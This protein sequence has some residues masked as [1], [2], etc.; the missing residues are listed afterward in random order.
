[1]KVLVACEESQ[2]VCIA[3]REK[4]HEAYSCDILMPSGGHPE[5][6]ILGDA[7]DAIRGGIIKT[8]DGMTHDVGRFEFIIGF[9]P[10]TYMSAAG[11]CRMYPKKG[12]I[13]PARYE[14]AMKAKE[15]FLTILNTECEKVVVENP[16]PLKIIGL[17][18]PTQEVQPW[19]FGEPWSKRTLLWER[20][21]PPLKPT[22]IITD[23]KP[24]V[25]AGTSRKKGGDSYGARIPH[26]GF[27]RSKTFWGLA[28]AM[29][30]Q[31]G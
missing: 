3:F 16:L 22:N 31:W 15:F 25:P 23:Y 10:C 4:G 30:E 18:P 28:R 8:L 1:M 9:P 17:P 14:K 11:A 2:R 27:A 24:F 21:V 13:D 7:L 6:H 29:A 20:G 12:Q 26:D 19:M 5:W